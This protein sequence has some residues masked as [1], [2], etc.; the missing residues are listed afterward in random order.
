MVKGRGN[1]ETPLRVVELLGKAVSENGLIG[2][3]NATGVGKS[4]LS[5]YVKGIGEPTTATLQKL[6]I[7]FGVSVAWLRGDDQGLKGIA[8]LL[9]TLPEIYDNPLV[10][11][12]LMEISQMSESEKKLV[13]VAVKEMNASRK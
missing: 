10:M 1:K 6:S 7:Y 2:I 12:I 8:A 3:E 5:R 9:P 13:L 4:A 11:K